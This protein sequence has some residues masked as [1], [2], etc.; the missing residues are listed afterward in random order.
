M[1]PSGKN[2]P[3]NARVVGS[4]PGWE[5]SLGIGDGNPLQYSCLENPMDRGSW[6]VKVHG[7]TKIPTQL[8]T[9]PCTSF[10]GLF[11]WLSGRESAY[12]C[13]KLRFKSG[14]EDPLEKEIAIYP[15]SLAWEITR[16]EEPNRPQFMRLQKSPHNLKTKQQRVVYH[17]E[18]VFPFF[19]QQ[20]DIWMLGI[21]EHS[22]A[23]KE[24]VHWLCPH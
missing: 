14:L 18:T 5:R 13:R 20:T 12:Q 8:S 1:W 23:I 19:H 15:S 3:A 9:H 16:T 4:I 17:A 11:C 10:L 6:W 7:I 21:T 22:M 2:L 24:S